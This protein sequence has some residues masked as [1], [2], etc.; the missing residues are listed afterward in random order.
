MMIGQMSFADLYQKYERIDAAVSTNCA[1]KASVSVNEVCAVALFST[2]VFCPGPEGP[3]THAGHNVS[4][5]GRPHVAVSGFPAEPEPIP[6]RGGC[7][8]PVTEACVVAGHRRQM[9]SIPTP[10]V[11][12]FL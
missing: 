5:P 7:R 3:I 1:S 9:G 10:E 4:H 6:G 12:G 8:K 2:R 11:G